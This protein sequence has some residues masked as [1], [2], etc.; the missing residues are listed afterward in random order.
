[1]PVP[2]SKYAANN[3][4]G[5]DL[6]LSRSQRTRQA[7][8]LRESSRNRREEDSGI[9]LEQ[10]AGGTTRTRN[11]ARDPQR[12]RGSAG[13]DPAEAQQQTPPQQPVKLDNN[14]NI[15]FNQSKDEMFSLT[16]GYKK[17]QRELKNWKILTNRDDITRWMRAGFHGHWLTVKIVVTGDNTGPKIKLLANIRQ[18]LNGDLFAVQS[19]AQSSQIHAVRVFAQP[20]P[21]RLL[22]FFAG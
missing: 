8:G 12:E 13:P 20:I 2:T 10:A 1:M 9:E 6:E 18:C 21:E 14:M 3:E 15:L 19:E 22:V 17:F 16:S 11:R 7:N 5:G 4:D